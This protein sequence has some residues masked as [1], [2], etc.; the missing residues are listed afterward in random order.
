MTWSEHLEVVWCVLRNYA[1]VCVCVCSGE[2]NNKMD[3]IRTLSVQSCRCDL[4]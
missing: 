4:L 3:C 2:C 1:Y